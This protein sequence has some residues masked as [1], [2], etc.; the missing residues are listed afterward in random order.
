MKNKQLLCLCDMDGTLLNTVGNLSEYSQK[1]LNMLLDKG[2]M[3]SVSSARTPASISQIL[4]RVPITLPVSCMNGAT[5]YDINK[6]KFLD[7]HKIPNDIVDE[8]YEFFCSIGEN[9]FMHDVSKG[10]MINVY[11]QK[12]TNDAQQRFHDL[13][14]NLPMIN[15]FHGKPDKN[16]H[17]VHMTTLCDL[18][19]IS[20]IAKELSRFDSLCVQFYEEIY[21][22]GYYFLDIYSKDASKGVSLLEIKKLSGAETVAAFGDNDNDIPMLKA[23]DRKS[24]V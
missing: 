10:N 5:L 7:C 21:N 17:I 8:I 20:S 14:K 15:Y 16:S 3:F 6:N 1:N 22:K 4:E 2:A 9:I 13:R 19:A 24:V 18:G 12:I 23:A 11:Y